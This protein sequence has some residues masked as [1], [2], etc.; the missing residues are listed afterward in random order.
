MPAEFFS[1]QVSI[2]RSVDHVWAELNHA[3]TWAHIG[4]VERVDDAQFDDDGLKS[5]RWST[6]VGVRSFGGTAVRNEHADL[7]RLGFALDA[8]EMTGSIHTELDGDDEATDLIVTLGI[9]ARG[10]LSTM[11]FTAIRDAVGRGLPAQVDSFAKR[12]AG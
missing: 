5:F 6:S 4:P 2:P 3:E 9:E 11:F 7:E 10:I 8:G 12:I 1:H